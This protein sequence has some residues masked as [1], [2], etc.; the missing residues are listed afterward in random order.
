MAFRI[1]QKVVC[2]DASPCPFWGALPLK[3][4]QIYTVVHAEAYG[5][6]QAIEL[7]EVNSPH[8]TNQYRACR[9]RPVVEQSTDT[10]MAVLRE[11]LDRQTIKECKPVKAGLL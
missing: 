3:N 2:V 11:I 8:D 9:F 5:S 10:G 7:A 6:I 1:G 4:N